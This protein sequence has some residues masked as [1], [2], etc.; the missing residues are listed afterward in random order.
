MN[1]K[2]YYFLKSIALTVALISSGIWANGQYCIPSHSIQCGSSGYINNVSTTGG[3]TNI[4]NNGTGC[5]N[6]TT[7]YSDYTGNSSM[8]VV[9]NAGSSVS[10]SV[11]MGPS[12]G[13]PGTYIYRAQ[14]YVDWN[15]DGTFDPAADLVGAANA[16]TGNG[17]A[18]VITFNV[19]LTAKNGLTR[20]RIRTGTLK[21]IP[22]SSTQFHPCNN[23]QEGEAE[24]YNF[25]VINPCIPPSGLAISDVD[26]KSAK[27][28][29]STKANA[30]L[31]EYYFTNDKSTI[32]PTS[33]GYNYTTDTTL[34]YDN[35]ICDTMYYIY[36]RSVCDTTGSTIFWDTSGWV[37]DSFR[38]PPCCYDPNVSVANVSSSTAVAS[39]PPV[40]SAYGYEYI[41]ST[42]STLPQVIQGTYTTYTSAFLQGLMGSTH[43]YV[44]VRSRCSP[45]PLSSWSR[46]VFLTQPPTSVNSI[47][48]NNMFDVT[49]YP[50]PVEST[51]TIDINGKT[52]GKASIY[53]IDVTGKVISNTAVT[54][55]K[56]KIDMSSLSSGIYTVKYIDD[57]QNKVL[58]VTKQ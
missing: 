47:S 26:Y 33:I 6:S 45:T 57:E 38:T 14:I 1:Q 27:I 40:G 2:P 42:D 23:M 44:H 54:T 24:D 28:G 41:V 56:V 11:K 50:N 18:G 32:P 51:L 19:P 53:L 49:A 17:S 20:M 22:A 36:L 12:G 37:S 8:R 16:I 35:L 34:S 4:T 55:N 7:S 25:E 15:Q 31:Y 43:Y 39:W 58:K 52:T 10:V 30:K 5:G 29:W 3:T 9:Q 46:R 21:S 48:G 13:V